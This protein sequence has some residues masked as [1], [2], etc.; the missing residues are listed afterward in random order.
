MI[1]VHI[2]GDKNFSDVMTKILGRLKLLALIGRFFGIDA[3]MNDHGSIRV[4]KEAAMLV[5]HEVNCAY[6]NC[7]DMI[8]L[9]PGNLQMALKCA[10]EVGRIFYANIHDCDDAD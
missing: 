8:L 10:C 9:K 5:R 6:G 3:V 1:P 2:R 4:P 7:A